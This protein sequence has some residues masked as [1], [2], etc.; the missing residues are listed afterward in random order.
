M[1][2]QRYY[3]PDSVKKVR[4]AEEAARRRSKSNRSRRYS[5]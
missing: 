3:E 4:K 5:D 1:K 2:T